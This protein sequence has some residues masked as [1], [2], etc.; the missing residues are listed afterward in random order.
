M[1]LYICLFYIMKQYSDM[2]TVTFSALTLPVSLTIPSPPT[3][4]GPCHL[5]R[6]DWLFA[7]DH[8]PSPC[9]LLTLTLKV[10]QG[11]VSSSA[12]QHLVFPWP[13]LL[14]P[15]SGPSGLTGSGYLKEREGRSQRN[16]F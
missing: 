13:L 16:I 11:V 6:P 1:Y 15:I 8:T 14:P 3:L 10:L 7:A 5:L 2:C 4:P 12:L 9:C